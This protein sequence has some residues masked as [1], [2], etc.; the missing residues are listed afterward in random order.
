MNSWKAP[1]IA[2][3]MVAMI[4]LVLPQAGAEKEVRTAIVDIDHYEETLMEFRSGDNIKITVRA[5]DTDYPISVFLL[6]GEEARSAWVESEE[7][8]LEAIK[9]GQGVPDQNTTFQVVSPFSRRNV[10]SFDG[11][12]TIGEHDD[13]YL[14]IALYRDSSMSTDEVLH[15]RTTQVDYEVE[16]KISEKEIPWHIALFAVAFFALGVLLIILYFWKGKE[17]EEADDDGA[18]PHARGRAP[19]GGD[20]RRAPPRPEGRSQYQKANEGV[21]RAPPRHDPDD[22]YGPDRSVRRAPPRFR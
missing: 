8:D 15:E 5:G 20:I 1:L 4:G 22:G 13:Y 17:E 2:I 21:R 7:V 11:S 18:P 10:T 12:I 3:L 9:A 14:I 6:K 19:Y 16:W